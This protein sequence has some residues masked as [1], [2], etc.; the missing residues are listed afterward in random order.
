MVLTDSVSTSIPYAVHPP[1]GPVI[2]I[3]DDE[4]EIAAI[5]SVLHADGYRALRCHFTTALETLRAGHACPSLIVLELIQSDIG[6]LVLCSKLRAMTDVPLVV[7]SRTR[8]SGDAAACQRLGANAFVHKSSPHS[9]LLVVIRRLVPPSWPLASEDSPNSSPVCVG[10]LAVETSAQ[11]AVLHGTPIELTPTEHRL[12][13]VLAKA[14]GTVFSTR[15]LALNLWGSVRLQRTRSLS[16][17]VRRIRTKL[18]R[19]SR[20]GVPQL[21]SIRGVGY[22]LTPPNPAP[23]EPNGRPQLAQAA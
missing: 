16:A 15:D 1:S 7:Y 22:S 11:R 20:S 23:T 10:T 8:R 5:T 18:H 2:W 17:H 4:P 6:G 14:P 19:V 21:R 13:L 12:L 9:D 3:L